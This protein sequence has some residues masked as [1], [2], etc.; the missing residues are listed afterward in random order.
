MIDPLLRNERL[1]ASTVF[2]PGDFPS[3]TYVARS[4]DELE[5]RLRH[6][7][8]SRGEVVS[9]SGPSKAGKTVLVEKVVGPDD[10]I[11]ITGSGLR[12]GE[13][14]WNRVLDWMG[15]PSGSSTSTSR[16]AA[17]E[18]SGTAGGTIGL[19]LV[20]AGRASTT[21]SA[22]GSTA[23][24]TSHSYSRA[25]LDQVVAEIS[26]SAFVLLI[27][28]F[29]YMDRAV[30]TEVAQQIK[31]AARR[32]VNICVASVPHRADDVVRSNPELRGRVQAIDVNYW[33]VE[34][35]VTIGR[36]G[37]PVLGL[38]VG[39]EILTRFAQ[40]ASGS[41]QLMQASCLDLCFETGVEEVV[42]DPLS[43][44]VDKLTL[45][46]TLKRTSARTD[47]RSL[48]KRLHSG[49]KT[50]G[51]ERKEYEFTDG[52]VGDVYRCILMAIGADPPQLTL[53]YEE[54]LAR[55]QVV[56]NGESPRSQ[57]IYQSSA[58]MSEIAGEMYPDQRVLEWDDDEQVLAII[59]PY[60]LF[61]LRWSDAIPALGGI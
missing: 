58:Q 1:R 48:L 47:Y 49:P 28:D 27:D 43:V 32:G 4:H 33:S 59:D 29:H 50:R 52:T 60:L 34:E 61:F 16:E 2:T 54:L 44:E 38:E 24:G 23:S 40:E 17:G 36:T 41:P 5:N 37:F 14:L 22:G 35:L 39:D 10:L 21:V 25:G 26:D 6:A 11:T 13:H 53:G 7:L 15:S 31:E 3:Y 51:T 45:E 56:V 42:T 55:A 12:S 57:S 19:P 9:I 30:Q 46:R 18:I 8:E 20:A